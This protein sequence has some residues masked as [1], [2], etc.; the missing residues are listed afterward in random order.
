MQYLLL[1]G[2]TFLPNIA[3]IDYLVTCHVSAVGRMIHERSRRS[4]RTIKEEKRVEKGSYFPADDNM[5]YHMY[6]YGLFPTLI[7]NIYCSYLPFFIISFFFKVKLWKTGIQSVPYKQYKH[8]L[9]GK[10]AYPFLYLYALQ[11][12][13]INHLL[14]FLGHIVRFGKI[15]ITFLAPSLGCYFSSPNN[16]IH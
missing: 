11:P 6:L 14:P 8:R 5:H 13:E 16:F 15:M 3:C 10:Y 2:T 7:M 4:K 9:C 12:A 1:D